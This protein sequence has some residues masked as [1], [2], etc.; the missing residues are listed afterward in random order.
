MRRA[1]TE[2]GLWERLAAGIT[3]PPGREAM[4]RAYLA[5]Y[6]AAAPEQAKLAAQ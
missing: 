4:A 1:A 6:R 3:P 5:L 2:E